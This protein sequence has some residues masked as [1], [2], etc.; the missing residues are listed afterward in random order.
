MLQPRIVV[1]SCE[2]QTNLAN[3]KKFD[4]CEFGAL[5]TRASGTA[6]SS[7]RSN[8]LSEASTAS[9]DEHQ[10]HPSQTSPMK[11]TSNGACIRLA[12]IHHIAS[13]ILLA[14]ILCS[15]TLCTAQ[16]SGKSFS[17]RLFRTNVQPLFRLFRNQLSISYLK[18]Q[19]DNAQFNLRLLRT[20]E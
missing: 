13:Y 4:W 3:R 11:Q 8:M 16:L 6:A 2:R 17:I 20:N 7:A 18:F 12:S 9:G 15:G 1:D 19:F 5:L 14:V 10:P